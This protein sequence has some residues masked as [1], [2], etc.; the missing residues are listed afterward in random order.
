ML[1]QNL[2]SQ[3]AEL[4]NQ[5]IPSVEEGLLIISLHEKIKNGEIDSNFS[6][7]DIQ[8][9]IEENAPLLISYANTPNKERLLKNLLNFFIERPL[10]QKNLYTLT[11]Y[12]RK[13][14]LLLEHKLHSPYR[15]FPLRESFKRYTNFSAIDIKEINQFESWFNQGFQATTRENVFD[16]L[17]DLKNQVKEAIGHLNKLLYSSEIEPKKVVS[18]FS[19]IF[20][21]LGEKADEI[22]DTLRL[23]NNLQHE[24][25]LVVSYFYEKTQEVGNPIKEIEKEKFLKLQYSFSRAADI[26]E[27]ILLFFNIVDNKLGQL[28]EHIQYASTKL[29]ELQDFL[30]Y[31]TQ[32][33]QNLRRLLEFTMENT[34][35]EKSQ[36]TFSE[37]Y[38]K[39]FLIQEKF[40]LTSMPDIQS[41][42]SQNNLVIYISEDKEYH[43][44]EIKLIET[45][46]IRQQ[47]T[48]IL[49]NQLKETL[50]N[51]DHLDLTKEFY[52]ILEKED[53]EETALQVVYEVIQYAHENDELKVF[54]DRV[55]DKN[56]NNKSILTCTTN[57]KK[58]K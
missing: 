38:S 31:Q 53:D 32:F 24:I 41:N 36:I 2:T 57:I 26:K 13:F 30:K 17:E 44:K 21:D 33:R 18:D 11:E 52:K 35:V 6:N 56:Y 27:E 28:R 34:A 3:I 20:S 22:R 16:H 51:K 12:S 58:K 1:K 14:V 37:N 48:A 29:N 45:E 9:T 10:E 15:E 50:K 8:R 47:R 4:Y 39:K 19:I 46:L 43:Q 55:L 25:D 40:K 23:G 7:Q 5:L 54:I 49:F 42:P